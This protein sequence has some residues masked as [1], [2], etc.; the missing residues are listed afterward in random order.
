MTS[1]LEHTLRCSI[2]SGSSNPGAGKPPPTLPSRASLR[3]GKTGSGPRRKRRGAIC[4]GRCRRCTVSIL[5][6]LDS[7]TSA[8]SCCRG[9]WRGRCHPLLDHKPANP[10]PLCRRYR[11]HGFCGGNAPQTKQHPAK[12]ALLCQYRSNP[13]PGRP[14]QQ[15]GRYVG[16]RSDHRDPAGGVTSCPGFLPGSGVLLIGSWLLACATSVCGFSSFIFSPCTP[17]L[18][19][20][21]FSSRHWYIFCG[22]DRR[23]PGPESPLHLQ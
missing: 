18:H 23:P 9:A 8:G 11:R 5:R 12:P 22:G 15:T 7:E 16:H 19:Y 21:F 13:L 10:G 17:L 14:S 1:R 3:S 20:P 2:S 4:K 6:S